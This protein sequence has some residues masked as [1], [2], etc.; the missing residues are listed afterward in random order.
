[1]TFLD[2]HHPFFKP[3]WVRIVVTLVPLIWAGVELFTGTPVW[4]MISLALGFYAG[5]QLFWV[6]YKTPPKP[7]EANQGE[8]S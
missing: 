4:A 6:F 3:L 8:D 1:M 5:L 7:D 2:P